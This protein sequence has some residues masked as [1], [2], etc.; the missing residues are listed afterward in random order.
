MANFKY[1]KASYRTEEVKQQAGRY[2]VSPRTIYRWQSL[3]VTLSDPQAVCEHIAASKRPSTAAMEAAI[4]IL[5][6]NS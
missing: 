1:K 6:A 5:K 4:S 2:G 3:G